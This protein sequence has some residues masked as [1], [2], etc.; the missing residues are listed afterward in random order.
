[1]VWNTVGERALGTILVSVP[2]WR[3][4]LPGHSDMSLCCQRKPSGGDLDRAS[5]GSRHGR[6]VADTTGL[7]MATFTA[8]SAGLPVPAFPCLWRPRDSWSTRSSTEERGCW[9]GAAFPAAS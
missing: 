2:H 5:L 3:G 7:G 6:V 1:M 9:A 4:T 8:M